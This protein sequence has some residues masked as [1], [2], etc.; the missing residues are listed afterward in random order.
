MK[1]SKIVFTIAIAFAGSAFAESTLSPYMKVGAKGTLNKVEKE[2]YDENQETEYEYSTEIMP[3]FGFGVRRTEGSLAT[4][5]S[6]DFA[7]K[8]VEGSEASNFAYTLPKVMVM[9][10][11]FPESFSSLYFGVGGSL[12]GVK[13][14]NNEFHGL[15]A[16]ASVGAELFN[17]TDK[18]KGTFQLD[19][20]IPAYA[21]MSYN[22]TTGGTDYRPYPVVALKLG[23]GF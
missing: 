17:L 13:M 1:L 2:I 7:T 4:D 11:V 21:A 15:F 18:V 12:G 23:F 20:D 6:A 19:L 9:K 10:S 5:I 8:S 14:N 16:N 22:D 3:M